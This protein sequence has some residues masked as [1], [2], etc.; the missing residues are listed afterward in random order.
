MGELERSG[1][2]VARF[3]AV[4][5]LDPQRLYFWRKR[6]ERSVASCAALVEVELP[7]LAASAQIEQGT[8]VEIEL[9]EW[10]PSSGQR[11]DRR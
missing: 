5:D 9:F 6:V 11:S 4:H 3:A 7:K 1:L 10:S 8:Q 2:G